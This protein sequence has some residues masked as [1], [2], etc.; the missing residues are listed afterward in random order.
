[1][2]MRISRTTVALVSQLLGR[3]RARA[4]PDRSEQPIRQGSPFLP[5][6]D[7][8]SRALELTP[9]I[10]VGRVFEGTGTWPLTQLHK[11]AGIGFRGVARP[12]VVGY[13]DIGYGNEGV[14]VFTGLNY[15][16]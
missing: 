12:F 16:F 3:N 13:V 1:M 10:D 8:G 4:T 2:G 14:A 7:V 9:F 15:P 6:G 5:A 11:V